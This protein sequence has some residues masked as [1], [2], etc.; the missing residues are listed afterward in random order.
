[1]MPRDQPI[2]F[3]EASREPIVVIG[4]IDVVL[5]VFFSAPHDLHRSVDLLGDRYGLSDA[6]NVQPP[7]EAAP[8]QM[9]VHLDLVGRVPGHLRRRGLS[10]A[11]N[12]NSHPDLAAVLGHV[13]C[14]V[15]WLHGGMR[16][17]RHLVDRLDFFD[18]GRHAP[19]RRRHLC[20]RPRPHSARR[21]PFAARC[22]AVETFA[23]GPSSQS[24][25]SA[26]RPCIAA[27]I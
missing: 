10:P 6:V 7:T 18:G 22:S 24:M 4:P 14:A 11:D 9:I 23:F 27:H 20:G 5:D 19:S 15:H 1:M 21:F 25:S 17:E 13:N 16:E 12:L 2:L 26:A 3:V 8:D